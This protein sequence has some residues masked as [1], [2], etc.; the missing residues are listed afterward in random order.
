MRP[1]WSGVLPCMETLYAF[2]VMIGLMKGFAEP[3]KPVVVAPIEQ[4]R[5][6][7]VVTKLRPHPAKKS[8]WPLDY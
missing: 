7:E 2:G 6:A 3:P 8:E 5:V 1:Q 4:H